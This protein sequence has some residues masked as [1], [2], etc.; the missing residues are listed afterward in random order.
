MILQPVN[1]RVLVKKD[2]PETTSSGGI[3]IPDMSI[4]KTTRGVVVAVGPGKYS[5][6][7]AQL[8]PMTVNVGD[9]VMFHPFA[10]SELRVGKDSYYCMP[11]S[12]V[13]L[14]IIDDEKETENQGE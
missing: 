11:E 4:E 9:V 3:V 6:K 1:D 12:D 7:T 2:E 10:G 14:K 5:E 13:W 8:I